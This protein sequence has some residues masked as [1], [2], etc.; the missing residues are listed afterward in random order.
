MVLQR[1]HEHRA[2][3]FGLRRQQT[4]TCHRDVANGC[5]WTILVPLANDLPGRKP[6]GR[7][8]FVN[9]AI[10]SYRFSRR[11]I[12]WRDWLLGH[13]SAAPRALVMTIQTLVRPQR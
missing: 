13:T 4:D 12:G 11:R 10:V 1:D 9:S 7:K 6:V 3:P 2:R 8:S 5:A